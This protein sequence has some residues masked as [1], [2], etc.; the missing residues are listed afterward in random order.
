[1]DKITPVFE[2]QLQRDTRNRRTLETEFDFLILQK[3]ERL[4]IRQQTTTQASNTRIEVESDAMQPRT[5]IIAVAELLFTFDGTMGNF[6]TWQKQLKSLK[7]TYLLNDK[8]TKIL[9]DMRLKRK[10][11][12]LHSRPE[13]LTISVEALSCELKTM[14]DHRPRRIMLHKK[15]E[16]RVYG[17]RAKHSATMYIKKFSEILKKMRLLSILLTAFPI[18]YSEIKPC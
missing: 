12:W 18:V 2:E 4:K 7:R 8:H 14:F 9:I 17:R 11:E 5:N 3:V 13:F 6:E 16:E 1:M 10:L 15:F